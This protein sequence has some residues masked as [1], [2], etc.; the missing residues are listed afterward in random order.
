MKSFSI[1]LLTLGFVSSMCSTLWSQNE[2]MTQCYSHGCQGDQISVQCEQCSDLSID[3]TNTTLNGYPFLYIDLGT[4]MFDATSAAPGLYEFNVICNENGQVLPYALR[5]Y[6][7]DILY[8]GVPVN[9]IEVCPNEV[10]ALTGVFGYGN[11][12]GNNNIFNLNWNDG[13]TDVSSASFLNYQA[14]NEATITFTN[15]TND[16]EVNCSDAVQ[17][18]IT[19]NTTMNCT[20]SAT[21]FCA[22]QNVTLSYSGDT[23]VGSLV[24]HGPNGQTWSVTSNPFV[25]QPVM[26]GG[27]YLQ[28]ASELCNFS[29]TFTLAVHDV[30]AGNIIANDN[31]LCPGQSAN[32]QWQGGVGSFTW[33]A[34]AT[35]LVTGNT[36]AVVTP[37]QTT[38]Y[39]GTVT[40]A[41]C[42]TNV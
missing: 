40:D 5:V 23:G 41:F 42:Q 33:N 24:L 11:N 9:T 30:I 8:Q 16:L 21:E 25:F 31:S 22:G 29:N 19:A 38:T 15:Y 20:P 18:L 13:L 4:V 1:A 10:I 17:V 28:N 36:S 12:N 2:V 39:T 3:F 34:Q 37:V 6:G 26:S 14:T 35:L 7:G 27:Y 32:L